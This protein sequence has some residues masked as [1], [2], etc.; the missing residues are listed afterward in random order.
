[1]NPYD[2]ANMNAPTHEN[3][4]IIEILSTA[5]VRFLDAE[6]LL[7]SLRM[8]AMSSWSDKDWDVYGQRVQGLI[9]AGTGAIGDALF[10]R[11]PHLEIVSNFGVGYDRVDVAAAARRGIVVT[12]TPDILTDEVADFTVGL[13][14]S[15]IRRIPQAN[16]FVKRGAWAAGGFP[17]TPSLRGRHVGILGLGRI[18]KAVARRCEAFG[19]RIS[20]CGRQPQAG[21]PYDYHEN[22]LALC[23]AVDTLI[24]LAPANAA[25][26]Q[27]VGARE[28]AA[29]GSDGVLIN[30]ARGSLI[31][32]AALVDA[33]TNGRLA[34]AGL[35]VF[36]NEPHA[37]TD[38]VALD[39]VVA[40]PHVASASIATRKA[41]A[42]LVGDNLISWFS[43]R[44]PLTPVPETNDPAQWRFPRTAA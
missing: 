29:L 28:L 35:D 34:G 33:L 14:I 7:P 19:L 5:A 30:V 36:E 12:N 21:V 16:A 10:E 26:H 1:M 40:V 9:A 8:H 6:D 41:M 11:L 38:L 43:G 3:R 39:Q 18:G 23:E 31:D 25:T 17:L 24:V 27:L 22:V 13:L 32:E 4:S 42:R 15:T 20:Y 44:G 2:H 37:R